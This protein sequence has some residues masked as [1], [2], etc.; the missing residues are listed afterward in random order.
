MQKRQN[1]A[2]MPTFIQVHDTVY[3]TAYTRTIPAIKMKQLESTQAI[4][5]CDLQYHGPPTKI[6]SVFRDESQ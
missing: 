2:H 4:N 1:S 5:T 6:E 3:F